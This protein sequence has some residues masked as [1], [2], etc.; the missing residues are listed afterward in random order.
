MCGRGDVDYSAKKIREAFANLGELEVHF[1]LAAPRHNVSPTDPVPVVRREGAHLTLDAVPWGVRDPKSNAK[2]P[3]TLVRAESVEHGSLASRARG[4]VV[5]SKFYEWQGEK[6]Q[7]RRPYAVAALDRRLLA[8]AA[9]CKRTVTDQGE[10]LESCTIITQPALGPLVEI[11]DR[12]PVLVP[13]AHF[14]T[15]LDPEA[16]TDAALTL[17]RAEAPQLADAL[18][19]FPEDPYVLAHGPRVTKSNPQRTLF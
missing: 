16:K 9:L 15:W 13:P 4:L 17:V 12:M 5:F 6:G 2:R 3:V 7:K 10:V 11:H 18:E 19:P 14:G 8:L 1:E